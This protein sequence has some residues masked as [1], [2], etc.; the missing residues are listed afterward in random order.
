MK[1]LSIY[2]LYTLLSCF[3]FTNTLNAAGNGSFTV[4][5]KKHVKPSGLVNY[6][7]FLADESELNGY[8]EDLSNNSPTASWSKN[9]R[10]SYWINVYNAFTIKLIID[11]YPVKSI[12][13]INEGKPWDLAFIKIG[14]KT[15]SLNHVENE[16]LRK[17]FD[18]P[19]IHFA[20]NCASISCPNL[21]NKA[22]EAETLNS[23]LELVTKIFINNPERNV[24][25]PSA[26]KISKLF[27]WFKSD[28]DN[29]G[30]VTA[31]VDRYTEVKISS[32]AKI[33]YDDYNWNLNEL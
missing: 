30:G 11:N 25:T 15:Y 18:E 7:G 2:L 33:L 8:L 23:Q 14:E 10:I 13:D 3:V 21:L 17:E 29:A 4:L 20:I 24:I 28:F 6:K 5:L 19:R 26:I 9:E 27:D 12:L 22:F 31:F 1:K 16:I 32:S